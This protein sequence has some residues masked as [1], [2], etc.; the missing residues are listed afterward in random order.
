[1]S[2]YQWKIKTSPERLQRWFP[3]GRC[4]HVN[5][6]K[7]DRDGAQ[8]ILFHRGPR[9]YYLHASKDDVML[10]RRAQV[11]EYCSWYTRIEENDYDPTVQYY[12]EKQLYPLR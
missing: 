12:E 5:C 7:W 11:Y 1:M 9:W 10:L 4:E 2:T 3:I 8:H 6:V